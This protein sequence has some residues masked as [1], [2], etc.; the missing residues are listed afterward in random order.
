MD[1]EGSSALPSA[2]AASCQIGSGR[3]TENQ[4][5]AASC[6]CS[7]R[8]YAAITSATAPKNANCV[9]PNCRI[10]AHMVATPSTAHHQEITAGSAEPNGNGAVAIANKSKPAESFDNPSRRGAALMP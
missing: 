5:C 1:A 9:A 3:E 8:P 7:T 6:S 10:G 4:G 2:S